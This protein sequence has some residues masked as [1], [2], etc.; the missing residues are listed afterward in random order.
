M[1]I[2]VIGVHGQ[3]AQSL[4]IVS[5]N[6]ENF[7]L[8]FVGRPQCDLT[9][10]EKSSSIIGLERPDVIINA[11]AYTAVD[12][13][14]EEYQ[15]AAVINS[16]AP[17]ILAEQSK[18]VGGKFVHISTDYVF[19]GDSVDPYTETDIANPIGVY[20]ATKLAGELAVRATNCDHLILRTS[21][22][23][24]PFGNNFV[25]TMLQLAVDR[26]EISI[27]DDQIGNPTSALDIAEGLMDALKKWEDGCEVGIGE[28]FHLAGSGATSWAEFAEKIFSISEEFS[29]PTCSVR[30]IPSTDYPTSAKRPANS[31]LNSSKYEKCF[32][33]RAP[34]WSVSLCRVLKLL[35]SNSNGSFR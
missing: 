35:L 25:K 27:V 2:L 1:K 21:W 34:H 17:G 8:Q 33:Y 22:V 7:F 5:Q 3:L 23:Y 13:A 10:L 9:E 4:K 31:C 11:A 18:K 24:S 16:I 20:G 14:E 12:K 15:L 26:E 30:R 28:T 6:Y 19:D 29:G 32:G